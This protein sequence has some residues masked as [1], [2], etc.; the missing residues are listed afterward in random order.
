MYRQTLAA[1]W[2]AQAGELPADECIEDIFT[3]GTGWAKGA[4]GSSGGEKEEEGGR[5]G[6][7]FGRSLA[8]GKGRGED[9]AEDGDSGSESR[10]LRGH[11][12][13]PSLSGSGG[14]SA[15]GVEFGH[16]RVSSKDKNG[17]GSGATS[18]SGL[19]PG[20]SGRASIE[21]QVRRQSGEA[22]Q[23]DSRSTFRNVREVDECEVREDLRS[24]E[25]GVEVG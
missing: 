10:T 13:G 22:A 16:R 19:N 25:I 12:R 11:A 24:W 14:G 21:Q 4:A 9:S 7:A 18:A 3:G 1:S 5:G 2:A 6:R 15:K 17:A 8:P 23:R 20:V